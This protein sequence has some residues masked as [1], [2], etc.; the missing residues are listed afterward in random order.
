[1]Q[2]LKAAARAKALLTVTCR[3]AAGQK[4]MRCQLSLTR[5]GLHPLEGRQEPGTLLQAGNQQLGHIVA[6]G[7]FLDTG[8][9]HDGPHV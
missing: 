2:P 1:M 5:A 8:L 6:A 3:A 7:S 4:L 9:G